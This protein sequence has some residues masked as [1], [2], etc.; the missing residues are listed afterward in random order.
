M[1]IY[2]ARA[3]EARRMAS[4]I[5]NPENRA[6]WEAIAEDWQHMAEQYARRLKP[7]RV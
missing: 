6:L 5:K 3:E 4:A 1:L 7:P 2:L